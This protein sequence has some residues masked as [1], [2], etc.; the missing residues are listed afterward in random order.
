MSNPPLFNCLMAFSAAE[1]W[2]KTATTEFWSCPGVL[3]IVHLLISYIQN[4]VGPIA[5]RFA[6]VKVCLAYSSHLKPYGV[7]LATS[8]SRVLDCS[9]IERPGAVQRFS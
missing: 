9:E 7:A 6:L 8:N 3:F 5:I 4:L 2:L 1:C